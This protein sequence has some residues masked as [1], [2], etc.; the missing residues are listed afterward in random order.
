MDGAEVFLKAQRWAM[1]VKEPYCLVR[2]VPESVGCVRWDS[3]G[4]SHLERKPRAV[5]ED[6]HGAFLDGVGFLLVGVYVRRGA[7]GTGRNH[8]LHDEGA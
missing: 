4:L 5:D 2:A 1:L 8:K 7:H 6:L 3:G